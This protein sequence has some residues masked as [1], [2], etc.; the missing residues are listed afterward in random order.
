MTSCPGDT[1]TRDHTVG[2]GKDRLAM[3]LQ[4]KED[5]QMLTNFTMQAL[6]NHLELAEVITAI[7]HDARKLR[8]HER[9]KYEQYV[10]QLS[11]LL[12]ESKPKCFLHWHCIYPSR[13][14]IVA[15]DDDADWLLVKESSVS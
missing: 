1:T 8:F 7:L 12:P 14:A 5:G 10:E 2:R 3:V 4:Q 15:A 11:L 9:P 13:P 6:Q